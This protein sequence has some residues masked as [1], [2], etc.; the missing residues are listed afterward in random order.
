MRI[1]TFE[2]DKDAGESISRNQRRG[3][4]AGNQQ[5]RPGGTQFGRNRNRGVG[6]GGGG[7]GGPIAESPK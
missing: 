4:Q 3:D 1:K 7:G 6:G 5:G 2:I